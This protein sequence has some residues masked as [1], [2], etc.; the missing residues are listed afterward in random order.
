MRRGWFLLSFLAIPSF[1]LDLKYATMEAPAGWTEQAAML[2]ADA[3][4][5]GPLSVGG[6]QPLVTLVSLARKIE[7]AKAAAEL[8][9]MVA[10]YARGRKSDYK[11]IREDSWRVKRGYAYLIEFAETDSAAQRTRQTFVI[12]PDG[13]HVRLLSFR[14]GEALHA[15]YAADVLRSLKTFQLKSR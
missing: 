3:V 10:T 15:R 2:G 9:E 4:F 1:A 6:E 5:I 11:V 8:R 13:A 14:G 7:P 12:V